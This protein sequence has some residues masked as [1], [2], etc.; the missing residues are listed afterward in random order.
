MI[1]IDRSLPFL[2]AVVFSPEAL[3][4]LLLTAVMDGDVVEPMLVVV[5]NAVDGVTDSK[6]R[7]VGTDPESTLAVEI[8]LGNLHNMV[9][10]SLYRRASASFVAH[11]SAQSLEA[12]KLPL[13]GGQQC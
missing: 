1:G 12:S 5:T 10:A 2:F 13:L 4:L 11:F 9:A 8:E 6:T 7:V 3:S